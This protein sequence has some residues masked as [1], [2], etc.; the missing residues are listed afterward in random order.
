MWLL[1]PERRLELLAPDALGAA[2][3]SAAEARLAAKKAR[4]E[5]SGGSLLLMAV[6]ALLSQEWSSLSQQSH[7]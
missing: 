2:A 1:Q 4:L 7:I 3:R 5:E 6:S